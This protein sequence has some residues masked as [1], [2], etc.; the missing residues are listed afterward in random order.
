V[1]KSQHNCFLHPKRNQNKTKR[2]KRRNKLNHHRRSS[3]SPLE[4]S[5]SSS[6]PS[7]IIITITIT[8]PECQNHFAMEMVS[9]SCTPK[10]FCCGNGFYDPVITIQ[11]TNQRQSQSQTLLFFFPSHFRIKTVKNVIFSRIIKTHKHFQNFEFPF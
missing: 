7:F 3:S 9:V 2:T 5:I 11:T 1:H 4:F 8:V 6:T 10:P